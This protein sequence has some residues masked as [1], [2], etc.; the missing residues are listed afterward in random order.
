[1]KKKYICLAIAIMAVL[2][3]AANTA[4]AASDDSMRIIAQ[5]TGMDDAFDTAFKE[6][7]KGFVKLS[8][9]L[10]ICMTGAGVIMYFIGLEQFPKMAFNWMMGIGIAMNFGSILAATGLEHMAAGAV[11]GGSQVLAPF[12]VDLKQGGSGQLDVLSSMF[13]YIK[14][15]VVLPGARAVIPISLR[16]LLILTIIQ[17]SYDVSTK[18]ISGDKIKYLMSVIVKFGMIVFLEKNWFD[19]LNL[20][21]SLSHGFESLGYTMSSA[22]L[23]LKPDSIVNNAIV[24]FEHFN[25]GENMSLTSPGLTIINVLGAIAIVILL[26]LTAIEMFMARVEFYIMAMLVM[27]LI[28][29]MI[30]SKF[31]F[32]SDKAIGLMFNLAIKVCAIA[33]MTG[34]MVPFLNAYIQEMK[35]VDDLFGATGIVL[36]MVLASLLMYLLTK[37]ISSIVSGLL[38]GQPSLGGSMMTEQANK[39]VAA[40]MMAAGNVAGA[41]ANAGGALKRGFL[42]EIAKAAAANYTPY[43]HYKAGRNQVDNQVIKN[44]KK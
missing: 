41:K 21:G 31:S 7:A 43:K 42:T 23:D 2:L 27:P 12:P 10:G 38:S 6:I 26:F 44:M 11:S 20:M 9:L 3:M 19:G 17:A 30:T 15:K 29:F 39:A 1:M 28:P 32:L 14:E 5:G 36:Q 35:Q 16:I 18:L 25:F 37:H 13:I 4:L 40:G 8:R 22:G 34:M 24:I 33:F